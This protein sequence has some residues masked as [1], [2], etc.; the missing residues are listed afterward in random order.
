MR[1]LGSLIALVLALVVAGQPSARAEQS[2]RYHIGYEILLAGFSVGNIEVT[3]ELSKSEYHVIADTRNSGLLRLLAGFTSRA[4]SSGRTSLGEVRPLTHR[5]DNVW[6]GEKRYVRNAYG[7][8]G[9]VSVE[10]LPS[11]AADGRDQVPSHHRADTI[12][13]LS[14]A[15]QASLRAVGARACQGSLAVFDGRRRYDLHFRPVGE[16]EVSGPFYS[17]PALHCHIDLERIIGFS[18]DPWLPRA[19]SS[20]AAE[21]WFAPVAADLPPLPTRM[22]TDLGL[23]TAEVILVSL[24]PAPAPPRDHEARPSA[25]TKSGADRA[26]QVSPSGG[27]VSG[28]A[29][30]QLLEPRRRP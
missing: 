3:V 15:V 11:A 4:E 2:S 29:L 25:P 21:I 8:D 12:D 1:F 28:D 13:P 6:V 26:G 16:E 24:T 9:G 7:D 10:V 20:D 18:R 22:M 23:G 27:D 19:K 14:A 5:A 30:T 17:G